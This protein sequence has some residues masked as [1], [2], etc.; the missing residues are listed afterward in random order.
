MWLPRDISKNCGV[1]SNKKCHN[2]GKF[3]HLSRMCQFK[4]F[5]SGNHSGYQNKNREK[6]DKSRGDNETEFKQNGKP[7]QRQSNYKPKQYVNKVDTELSKSEIFDEEYEN[8]CLFN[9]RNYQGSSLQLYTLEVNN[10]PVEFLIDSGASC[11]IVT[12]NSFE[13]IHHMVNLEKCFKR[14]YPYGNN[15]GRR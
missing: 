12:M 5:D 1:T 6:F 11:N 10:V 8:H 7:R 9:V 15:V 4:R 2:C 14:V 13:K 3:G